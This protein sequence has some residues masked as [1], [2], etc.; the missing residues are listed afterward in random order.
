LLSLGGGLLGGT[1]PRL[2]LLG[3]RSGRPCLLYGRLRRLRLPGGR[4]RGLRLRGLG[5]AFRGGVLSTGSSAAASALAGRRAV[6]P[7]PL[8]LSSGDGSRDPRCSCDL[9]GSS[10]RRARGW[11]DSKSGARNWGAWNRGMRTSGCRRAA[12]AAGSAS[13]PAPVPGAALGRRPAGGVASRPDRAGDVAA[14]SDPGRDRRAGDL[15]G[16]RSSS[17][18]PEPSGWPGPAPGHGAHHICDDGGQPPG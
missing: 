4:F 8:C 6:W 3:G 16:A 9:G 17:I 11:I 1:L 2:C 18:R 10:A 15:S 12:P 7:R 14:R 13:G 5:R